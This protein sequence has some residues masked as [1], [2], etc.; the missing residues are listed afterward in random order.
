[1]LYYPIPLHMQKVHAHLGYKMGDLPITEKNTECVISL[2]MFPELTLE[3]QK[4]VASTLIECIEKSKA[5]A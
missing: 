3:E 1:M 5:L 2:P 4:T